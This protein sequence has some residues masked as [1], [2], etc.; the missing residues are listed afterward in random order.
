M[1]LQV[2]DSWGLEGEVA[3]VTGSGAAGDGIGNGRAAAILLARGGARVIVVD[4]A[5]DLAKR[6]VEM[7][8]AAGSEAVAHAADV[9]KSSAAAAPSS[10][11]P[12]RAGGTSCGSTAWRR[13]PSTRRW[14]TGAG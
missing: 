2:P 4:R 1:T 11:R 7:I 13:G 10:T 14:C 8:Q 5:G 9:T 6:T 12:R 3:I